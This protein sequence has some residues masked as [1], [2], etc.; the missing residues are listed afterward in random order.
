MCT[1]NQKLNPDIIY[2][3]MIICKHLVGK[4]KGE[5]KLF[6]CSGKI[7]GITGEVTNKLVA[8]ECSTF[9]C[10]YSLIV[11]VLPKGF[12]LEGA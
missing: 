10:L 8:I 5:A 2:S 7:L 6:G 11:I 9:K 1:L 4:Y 12:K 3:N